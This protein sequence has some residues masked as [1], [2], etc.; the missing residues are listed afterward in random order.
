M[1]GECF[2]FWIMVINVVAKNMFFVFWIII[3]NIGLFDGM[4]WYG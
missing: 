2:F 3:E 1:N 4:D